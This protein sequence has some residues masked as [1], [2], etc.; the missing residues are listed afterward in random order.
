MNRAA[1]LLMPLRTDSAAKAPP[2]HQEMVHTSRFAAYRNLIGVKSNDRA[3]G[4]GRHPR[5][6]RKGP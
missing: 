4:D 2:P 1:H 5:L 6:L 3:R